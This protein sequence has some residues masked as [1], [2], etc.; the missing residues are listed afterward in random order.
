MISDCLAVIYEHR[1][2]KVF[3]VAGEVL[4]DH[5]P[6]HGLVSR[7]RDLPVIGQSGGIHVSCMGHAKAACLLA[8]KASELAL[9]ATKVFGD[10]DRD[11]V[12]RPGYHRHDS[13]LDRDHSAGLEAELSWC[14]LGCVHRYAQRSVKPDFARLDLLKQ[15]IERHDL[16]ERGR[17]A[18]C[19][20]VQCLEHRTGIGVYHD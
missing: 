7:G 4:L 20:R 1:G 17:V 9:V 6:E 2:R 18:Q 3:V 8:H 11:I 12:R 10:R 19:I 13:V 5:A 14:L 15:Q 16:C